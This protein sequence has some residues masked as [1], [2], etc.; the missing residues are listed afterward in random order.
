MYS[1]RRVD[2]VWSI[3]RV[4]YQRVEMIELEL[5]VST[6]VDLRGVSLNKKANYRIRHSPYCNIYSI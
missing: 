3:W 4:R 1:N 2:E 6:W 5:H